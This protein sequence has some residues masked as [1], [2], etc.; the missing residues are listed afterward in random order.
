MIIGVGIDIIEVSRVS[1]LMNRKENFLERNF[2]EAEREFNLKSESVAGNFAAKEAFAKA[3]GTG[4][5]GFNLRDIEVLRNELGA[6]YILFR[7]ERSNAQVSISHT[8][9]TA[10]AVVIITE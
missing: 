8:K 9:T 5:R 4:V 3:L 2:T 6:P 10:V 7:G 1:E